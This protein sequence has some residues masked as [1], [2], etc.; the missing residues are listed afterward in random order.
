MQMKLNLA[1]VGSLAFAGSIST[2]GFGSLEK[3][4]SERNIE[5]T[6]RYN[7]SSSFELG[8]FFSEKSNVRIPMYFSVSEDVRNPQYNPLDPDILLDAALDAYETKEEKDSIKNIVQDYT[9]KKEY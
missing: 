1:D 9:K 6:R 7:V 2:V 8:K 5:E 3:N 4:V